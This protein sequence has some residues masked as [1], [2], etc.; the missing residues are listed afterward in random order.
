M[1]WNKYLEFSKL[2]KENGHHISFL[3]ITNYLKR[4]QQRLV[5]KKQLHAP[6]PRGYINVERFISYP[7][8]LSHPYDEEM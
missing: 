1:Q 6:Q 8:H 7:I 3:L 5:H 2:F 4:L